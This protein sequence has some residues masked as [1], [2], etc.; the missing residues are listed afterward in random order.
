M[1]V[2]PGPETV[3]EE[4]KLRYFISKISVWDYFN[5]SEST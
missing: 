2:S 1:T 4:E 5:I 3:T